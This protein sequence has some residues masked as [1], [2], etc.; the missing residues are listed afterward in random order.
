MDFIPV[1]YGLTV[2]HR[3]RL[4]EMKMHFLSPNALVRFQC[5][6]EKQLER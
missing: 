6:A 5:G 3:I 1:V 2:R 4:F